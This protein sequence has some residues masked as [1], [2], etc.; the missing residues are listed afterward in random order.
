MGYQAWFEHFKEQ[1]QGLSESFDQSKS[2]LSLL[3][4]S[5]KEQRLR[6]DDY[7]KWAMTHYNLPM[8]QSRFFTETSLSLEMFAKWATHYPWSEECLPVAE[9]DGSLIIA[10][11]QPPQDFPSNPSSIFVLATFENLQEAWRKFYPE[12]AVATPAPSSISND[13][14]TGIDLALATVKQQAPANTFSV[15]DLGVEESS[16]KTSSKPNPSDENSGV[17]EVAPDERLE[18]LLDDAPSVIRLERLPPKKV[19]PPTDATLNSDNINEPPSSATS[20]ASSATEDAHNLDVNNHRESKTPPPPPQSTQETAL[21]TPLSDNTIS[22]KTAFRSTGI[23]K[24][25][26]NPAALENFSLDKIKRKN[27]ALLGEKIKTTLSQMKIQFEK[28]MILTLDDQESQLIAFAWDENFHDIKD[29]SLSIPLKTP[30]IFSIVSST[31]KAFHGYISPNQ[32]NEDFFADWNQGRIPDHVTI[33]PIMINEKLVGMLMGF[34]SKSTYNRASL[35]LAE[36]L[37]T[38]FVKGLQAA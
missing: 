37:S 6:S 3:G 11:L 15:E 26:L 17:I 21:H 9:W 23:V 30:S 16:I 32:I 19:E 2:N 5:L 8:L 28:S 33:T 1:L 7:F 27:S 4:Y 24:P 35:N 13:A 34:G 38:D 36:K 31:Q 29:T 18:G 25:T 22:S 14:P 20:N 12:K 10:C